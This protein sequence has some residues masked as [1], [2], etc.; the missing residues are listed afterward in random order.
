VTFPTLIVLGL[1]LNCPEGGGCVVPVPLNEMLKLALEAFDVIATLPLKACADCGA[2]ITLKD[3]VCPGVK[4]RGVLN[5]EMLKS[6]PL[7]VACVMVRLDPPVL[8]NVLD[9]V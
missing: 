9:W 7:A 3:A 5:P 6:A 8:L 2:K 1:T 4:V